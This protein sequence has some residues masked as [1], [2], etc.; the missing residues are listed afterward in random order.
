MFLRINIVKSCCLFLLIAL[1]V[2]CQGESKDQ[3]KTSQKNKKETTT[4]QENQ[5]EVLNKKIEQDTTNADLYYQRCKLY[6]AEKELQGAANDI[7]K[8]MEIAPENTVYYNTASSI[9]LQINDSKSAI[10]ML[11]R[12]LEIKPR[13]V[14]LRLQLAKIY[15]IVRN[16][17]SANEN[18]DL[19]LSFDPN[20]S[21]AYWYKSIIAK[22][23]NK[24]DQA[25]AYLEKSVQSD[26]DFYD[27]HLQLGLLK[28]EKN[29][30]IALD[31]FDNAIRI[32]PKS[33]EA[34][35]AKGFFLQQ[36]A[37]VDEAKQA[38]RAIM[39]FN[40][41]YE[42]AYYNT[43]YLLYLQDSLELAEKH[44]NMAL[45]FAPAYANAYQ[46]RGL[47]AELQGKKEQAIRDYEQCLVFEEKHK[48]ALEGLKRVKK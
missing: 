45:K 29:D 33:E 9:L 8:A 34:Y 16:Y 4:S 46:M 6:L 3:P 30:T 39:K 25:I 15:L 38:Y 21:T 12:G 35:Y 37:R 36:N 24:R 32:N 11:E 47:M 23:Q 17:T 20:N 31:Y 18:L 28:S 19:A 42:N 14:S 44:F 22:E 40:P 13:D 7:L 43:G 48:K 27:G 1:L 26:P 10:N 5:L 2:A 41:Q